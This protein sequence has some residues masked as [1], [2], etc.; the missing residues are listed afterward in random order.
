MKSIQLCWIKI[1]PV[2][3]WHEFSQRKTCNLKYF[4]QYQRLKTPFWIS[5]WG[6]TGCVE[7]DQIFYVVS[8]T[9]QCT[10]SGPSSFPGLLPSR[11]TLLSGLET[12]WGAVLC[13]F[14]IGGMAGVVWLVCWWI[15]PPAR[16]FP[17]GAVKSF[18][19]PHSIESCAL[20]FLP[21]LFSSQYSC[22]ELSGDGW[23]AHPHG[24]LS[25]RGGT[26]CP[27]PLWN[28]EP[29]PTPKHSSLL[30]LP[31]FILLP[32]LWLESWQLSVIE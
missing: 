25:L 19:E 16:W 13:P 32:W 27:D 18:G 24:G 17:V 28:L 23:W 8:F 26:G 7:P 3:I 5:V 11:E 9:F 30:G 10:K 12:P 1:T 20:L 21:W 6:N 2:F 29:T 15:G 14:W 22:G 4:C 31:L